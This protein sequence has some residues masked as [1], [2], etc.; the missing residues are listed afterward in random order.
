MTQAS[1]NQG[2]TP[3][4]PTDFRNQFPALQQA[5]IYLDSAATA[6]KPLAVIAATQQFYR[7]DAATVHRSQHRAAQDLTA[8]F[9]QARRQVAMLIDAP[10]P[11]TLFGPAA[12]PRQSIWWRKAMPAPDCNRVMKSW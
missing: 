3:F 6:L 7:D 10:R 1:D 5:G 12:P 4:N 11:M 9:E 2:M 8:R